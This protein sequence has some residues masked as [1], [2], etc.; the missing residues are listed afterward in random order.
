MEES[1][2]LAWSPSSAV[3]FPH[4]ITSALAF[5]TNVLNTSP[6][7]EA[8]CIL[9]WKSMNFCEKGTLW[10]LPICYKPEDI[11]RTFKKGRKKR[12]KRK[13]QRPSWFIWHSP[14]CIGSWVETLVVHG[15]LP[16][17]KRTVFVR[18]HL[19]ISG[20]LEWLIWTLY[21]KV[22]LR[23]NQIG[24]KASTKG[25]FLKKKKGRGEGLGRDENLPPVKL[26]V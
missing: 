10:M 6:N 19:V 3:A 2:I 24:E 9:C 7:L 8:A 22:Q 20:A 14:P 17:C 1:I 25:I 12:K 16:A 18:K 21:S 5:K 26:F 11:S 4:T 23:K 13:R 15:V